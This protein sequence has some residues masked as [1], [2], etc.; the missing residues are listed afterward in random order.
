MPEIRRNIMNSF[1]DA[2][3]C[4]MFI[5]ILKQKWSEFDADLKEKFTVEIATDIADPRKH[6][7]YLTAQSVEDFKIVDDWAKKEVLP[8]RNRFSPKSNTFT[9]EL[10]ARF[11]FG[12][13]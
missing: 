6:T 1:K 9:C 13:N 3:E 5:M 4:Q 10:E 7:A 11:E 8:L 2:Q 12:D